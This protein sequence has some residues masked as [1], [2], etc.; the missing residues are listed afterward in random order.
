[1]FPEDS[2]QFASQKFWFPASRTDDVSSCPDAQ[3]SKAAA[4]RTMWHNVQTPIRLKHHL[5]GRRGFPFETSFVSRSFE[6]LQLASVQMNQLPVLTI[7]S[8]WSSF[9]IS[10]QT[11]IWE[12]CCNR[13]DD[14]DSYPDALIHKGSITIQI[15]TSGRQSTWSRR[16]Y[17]RYRNYVHQISRSENHPPCSDARSLYMDITCSGRRGT[18]TRNIYSKRRWS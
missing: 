12:D 4:I 10:F 17:I 5:S 2:T 6:L 8:V 18:Q 16:A 7:L 3:L 11:H 9:R 13:L 15:Q 1:V 14:V